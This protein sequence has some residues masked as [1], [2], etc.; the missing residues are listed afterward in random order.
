MAFSNSNSKNTKTE[1]TGGMMLEDT[2][3]GDR[4]EKLCTRDYNER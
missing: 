1:Q 2:L 3:T 4:S